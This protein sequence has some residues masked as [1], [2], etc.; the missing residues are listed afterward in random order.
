[1]FRRTASLAFG[2]VAAAALSQGPE[3]SQQYLQRLG[4]QIDE[5]D[6]QVAA[7]DERASE[8]GLERG[9]YV[10]RFLDNPDRV[11][12]REGDY[13]VSVLARHTVL[14]AAYDAI[15][16]APP[17]KRPW[18]MMQHYLPDTTRATF[19]AFRPAAPLTVDGLAY[20]GAGFLAGWLGTTLLLA[21]FGRGRNREARRA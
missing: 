3:F 19:A 17:W 8:A 9:E 20:A 12:A 2:I 1:M 6:A 10:R 21:P 7:L 5:V 15:V 13:M 14:H 18:R 16:V 11:I 4:G